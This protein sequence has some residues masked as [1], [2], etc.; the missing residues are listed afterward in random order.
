MENLNEK[1]EDIEKLTIYIDKFAQVG[2]EMLSNFSKIREYNFYHEQMLVLILERLVYNSIS[3]KCILIEFLKTK[4][5]H[6]EYSIGLLIRNCTSDIITIGYINYLGGEKKMSKNELEE[7]MKAFLGNQIIRSIENYKKISIAKYK[8]ISEKVTQKYPLLF[9]LNEKQEIM[10]LYNKMI[11][12]PSMTLMAEKCNILFKNYFGDIKNRW[13]NYSK[14]EH[15]GILTYDILRLDLN[16]KIDDIV[17]SISII[18]K[19]SRIIIHN[20]ADSK[21]DKNLYEKKIDLILHEFSNDF[22]KR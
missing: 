14:Y 15:L 12:V 2:Q 18:I 17:F 4:N 20:Q 19:A 5:P 16:K 13:L 3:I 7:E 22:F 10:E 8:E 6:L 21:F 9:E 11:K 1:F